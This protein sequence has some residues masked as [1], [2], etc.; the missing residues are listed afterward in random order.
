MAPAQADIEPMVG[1]YSQVHLHTTP[2]E[3]LTIGL[4][5][6]VIIS[7]L[8]FT[9]FTPDLV[10]TIMQRYLNLLHPGGILTY[11]TY[12]GT[13]Q[14]R[15]LLSS[16]ADSRR[17]RAV[18]EVLAGY[19]RQCATGC[20]TVWANLPPARVWQLTRPAETAPAP[21][22]ASSGADA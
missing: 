17:H 7:G 21:K 19:Q 1:A 15:T 14:A 2:V 8:P 6:D 11:F 3:E 22:P 4:R 12:R 9:N 16:R 10:D 13:R 18:E 5:H 20:W